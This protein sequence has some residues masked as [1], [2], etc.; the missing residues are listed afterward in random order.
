MIDEITEEVIRRIKQRYLLVEKS[1]NLTPASAEWDK[2]Q[3]K[4][5]SYFWKDTMP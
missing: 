5:F 1:F 2:D 3:Q 4:K